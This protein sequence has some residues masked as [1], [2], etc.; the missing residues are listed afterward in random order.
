MS[1]DEDKKHKQLINALDN[2]SYWLRALHKGQKEFPKSVRP[3]TVSGRK[4]L[5]HRWATETR[6]IEPSVLKGGH[7]GA[8]V[9]FTVAI[10]EYENGFVEEVE[11]HKIRFLDNIEKKD[12]EGK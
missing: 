12:A 2:I 10:V 7:S 11:P 8:A 9:Q 6:L 3:C 1:Y 4:A 5:F